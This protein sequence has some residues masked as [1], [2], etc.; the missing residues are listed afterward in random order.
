MKR[1]L[2][3]MEKYPHT[4]RGSLVTRNRFVDE[5]DLHY[6]G[7]GVDTEAGGEGENAMA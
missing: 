5:D 4:L 2:L 1:S 3:E 7:L 6:S